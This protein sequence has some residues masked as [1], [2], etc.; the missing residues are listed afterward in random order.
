M[1]KDLEMSLRAPVLSEIQTHAAGCIAIHPLRIHLR[2]FAGFLP[3]K[4][5]FSSASGQ[6]RAQ[7]A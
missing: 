7:R 6:N 4:L 3:G 5:W 2:R 1:R